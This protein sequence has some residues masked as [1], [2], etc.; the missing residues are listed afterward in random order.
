[1]PWLLHRDMAWPGS[2]RWPPSDTLQPLAGDLSVGLPRRRYAAHP[3]VRR[4]A[5]TTRQ[6]RKVGSEQVLL[7]LAVD[8]ERRRHLRLAFRWE[9]T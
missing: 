5:H 1:V 6:P 9:P 4:T 3:P 7:K 8:F 2:V